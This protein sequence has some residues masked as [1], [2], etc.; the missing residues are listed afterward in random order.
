[1]TNLTKWY[2]N[3]VGLIITHPFLNHLFKLLEYLN[4]E[5]QFKNEELQYRAVYLLHY[6]ATGQNSNI[7]E[8][9]LAMPKILAGMR[10]EDPITS[11]LDLSNIEKDNADEL[12]IAVITHWEKLGNTSTEGLQNTFFIRE[13]ILEEKNET[14]QLTVESKGVDILLDYI[15]WGMSIVKLPWVKHLIQI[16]WR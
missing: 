5:N 9:D 13:G 16:F 12:L 2:I 3:N 15:P 8:T 1:M 7:N 11:N 6:I 14:F 10:I 4:D